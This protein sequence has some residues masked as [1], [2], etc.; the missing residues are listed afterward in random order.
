MIVDAHMHLPGAQAAFEEAVRQVGA[1]KLMWGSDFPRTMVDFTY[2]QTLD[3]LIDG[4]AFLSDT[5][6]AAIL[7][8]TTSRV[9]GFRE[10]TEERGRMTRIT[11]LD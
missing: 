11:E 5:E 8:G 9:F 2:E 4:C 7:G 6:R 10:P 1:E 3:F